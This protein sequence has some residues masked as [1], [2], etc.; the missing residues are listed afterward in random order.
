MLLTFRTSVQGSEKT[1]RLIR[2]YK[3]RTRWWTLLKPDFL[4]PIL[5]HL[6][7]SICL[8]DGEYFGL[9]HLCLCGRSCFLVSLFPNFGTWRAQKK[10]NILFLALERMREHL[11]LGIKKRR[12]Q[13]TSNLNFR[14][15]LANNFTLQPNTNLR[16]SWGSERGTTAG[17]DSVSSGSCVQEHLRR[18]LR[19]HHRVPDESFVS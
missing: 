10:Y 2:S 16:P 13:V 17:E 14:F 3:L 11:A 7:R 15:K 12:P 18:S 19:P 1:Q 9:L 8:L 6:S 4:V 5:L